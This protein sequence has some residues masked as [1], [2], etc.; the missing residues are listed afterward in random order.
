MSIVDQNLP[1]TIS[2]L[3]DLID[4]LPDG[5]QR[6]ELIRQQRVLGRQLQTLINRNVREDTSRYLAATAALE[7]T[8]AALVSAR[9]DIRKVAETITAVAQAVEAIAAL[10]AS[11]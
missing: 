6:D 9:A 1:Q 4:D 8:N 3:T 11:L 2:Q 7:K 5:P 10:A